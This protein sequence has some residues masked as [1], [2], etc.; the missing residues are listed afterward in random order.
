MSTHKHDQPS[1]SVYQVP[2]KIALNLRAVARDVH[3]PE[4]PWARDCE[5]DL[6][7]ACY[8]LSEA[9]YHA[10]TDDRR[11]RLTPQQVSVEMSVDNVS[12]ATSHWFLEHDD[13]TIIDLTAEQFRIHDVRIPHHQARGRGF[14]TSDPSSAAQAIL[15][16]SQY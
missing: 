2:D 15:D 13:G 1:A 12:Y 11:D 7:G 14:L 6:G 8:A 16:Q 10:V 3:D 5:S 9:Y 4:S